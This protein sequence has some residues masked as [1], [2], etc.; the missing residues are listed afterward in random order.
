MRLVSPEL[1][2]KKV[3]K[4]SRKSNVEGWLQSS[5]PTTSTPTKAVN[6]QVDIKRNIEANHK[7]NRG[8]LL[9]VSCLEK[10]VEYYKSEATAIGYKYEIMKTK[11][12]Q[13]R[14]ARKTET[15]KNQTT[16]TTLQ[17]QVSYFM[18]NSG[19]STSKSAM[20]YNPMSMLPFQMPP[21]LP[22]QAPDVSSDESVILPDGLKNRNE[23]P[24]Q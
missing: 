5:V 14:K 16:I 17:Q 22:H 13:E 6:E 23:K 15:A 1:K 24:P 2:H 3:S 8:L 12:R 11:Y 19:A 18:M 10:N 20:P 4:K 9:K 7:N 21:M